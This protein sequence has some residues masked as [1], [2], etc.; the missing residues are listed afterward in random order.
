[1]Y[2]EKLYAQLYKIFNVHR[3]ELEVNVPFTSLFKY[4]SI[5]LQTQGF[6]INS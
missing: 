1:M 3:V 6:P 5:M 2:E 4:E